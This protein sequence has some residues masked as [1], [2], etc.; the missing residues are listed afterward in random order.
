M[1]P[2]AGPYGSRFAGYNI[3]LLDSAFLPLFWAMKATYRTLMEAMEL[4][5]RTC[6][7]RGWFNIQQAGERIGRHLHQAKF[8]GTFAARAEGSDTRFG[9]TEKA[10]EDD[11]VIPNKDGQ[12]L[13]TFGLNHYHETSE[14]ERTDVPRVTYATDI[15]PAEQWSAKT[16]QVPFDGPPLPVSGVES[17]S[18]GS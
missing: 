13:M 2:W 15:V 12:L 14:W 4:E 18:R 1:L 9:L 16:L 3:F 7:I 10:H 5:R 17:A 8:I 6:C 11:V